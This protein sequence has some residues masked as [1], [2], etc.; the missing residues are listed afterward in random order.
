M[1]REQEEPC[2][3]PDDLEDEDDERDDEDV[4][5]V[6]EKA[7]VAEISTAVRQLFPL[8]RRLGRVPHNHERPNGKDVTQH[9]HCDRTGRPGWPVPGDAPESIKHLCVSC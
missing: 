1:Y 7:M 8:V 5:E 9:G 2:A 6:L 3:A 4:V